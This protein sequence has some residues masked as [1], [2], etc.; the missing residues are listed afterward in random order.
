[1][2][3]PF[4]IAPAGSVSLIL[5]YTP[6]ASGTHTATFSMATNDPNSGGVRVLLSGVCPTPLVPSI[7][8]DEN[9]I[10]FGG[11]KW[12]QSLKTSYSISNTGGRKL[13]VSIKLLNNQKGQASLITP[14]DFDIE[15]GDHEKIWLEYKPSDKGALDA[16][17]EI[18]TNDPVNPIVL[19]SLT[20]YC[21]APTIIIQKDL[22]YSG[23]DLSI[24]EDKVVYISNLGNDTLKS[25]KV[26]FQ[27]RNASSFWDTRFPASIPPGSLGSLI[28]HFQP[29]DE[30]LHEA[31]LVF[32]TNDPELD[33]GRLSLSGTG[34]P[35]G[36][37][38]LAV[39]ESF[40]LLQCY[41][42]P[43][44]A[45]TLVSFQIHTGQNISLTLYDAAGRQIRTLYEGYLDRARYSVTLDIASLKSG[46]Y[47]LRLS[48]KDQTS[49]VMKV[50][51]LK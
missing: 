2:V 22:H 48:G 30:S 35:N 46:S 12:N 24:G 36:V 9:G 8:C 13:S 4:T 31:E 37:E 39:T 20:G 47:F 10:S 29:Q 50:T 28:I 5:N 49:K 43:V 44:V 14:G 26:G 40:E 27:G 1:M 19:K 15:P 18:S 7:Y 42:H 38:E 6:L 34:K 32:T 23:T 3:P 25:S 17:L 45:N 11:V 51:L 21:L 16:D 41:P 33:T